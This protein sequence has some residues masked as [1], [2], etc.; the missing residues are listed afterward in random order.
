[1]RTAFLILV[2][3]LFFSLHGFTQTRDSIIYITPDIVNQK[4]VDYLETST[5]TGAVYVILHSH[6][7]TTSILVS[8]YSKELESLFY[9]IKNSNRYIKI[10]SAQ[11]IPALL[12]EDFVMSQKLHT[13][14]NKGTEYELMGITLIGASGFLVEY[15][16]FYYDVSIIKAEWYQN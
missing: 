2:S 3:G 11:A 8:T 7:D 12:H 4:I 5:R 10:S 6:N 14:R 9:L 13:I 1:M 16:G 15:K